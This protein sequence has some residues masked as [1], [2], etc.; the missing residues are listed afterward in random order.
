MVMER[1]VR[2][3]TGREAGSGMDA[4][5]RDVVGFRYFC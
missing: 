5:L 1:F 2:R 3:K 4:R